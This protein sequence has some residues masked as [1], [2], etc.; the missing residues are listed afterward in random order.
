MASERVGLY[1]LIAQ[2]RE[3][4]VSRMVVPE[5]DGGLARDTIQGVVDRVLRDASLGNF[6]RAAR[7]KPCGDDV[8]LPLHVEVWDY[9]ETALDECPSWVAFR[10]V[11]NLVG[12]IDGLLGVLE[13]DGVALARSC[14]EDLD[15]L[16]V[17]ADWCDDCG[18][19]AVA[20]EARHLH[21]LVRHFRASMA[22]GPEPLVL[23]IEGAPD[24]EEG[25]DS[26]WE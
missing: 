12:R 15:A 5:H 3:C 21:G 14:R 22:G 1:E 7:A 23:W 6:G 11:C 18:R 9:I 25:D 20:A 26:E 13:H 19:P 2:A 24:F 10:E 17:L 8:L 16:L 4:W